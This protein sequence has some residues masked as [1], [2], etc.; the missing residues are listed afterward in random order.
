[1]KHVKYWFVEWCEVDE[2]NPDQPPRFRSRHYAS[3]T[4]ANEFAALARKSAG[5]IVESVNVRT[6]EGM[7]GI[8]GG[9]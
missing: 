4:T 7:D 6:R 1:M 9:F 8:G 5:V 3:L 2:K